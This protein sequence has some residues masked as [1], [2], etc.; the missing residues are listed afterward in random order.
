[1]FFS[2]I[3]KKT[4][5][6]RIELW[7]LF[8]VFYKKIHKQK[9][10]WKTWKTLF[11]HIFK[12]FCMQIC[13]LCYCNK[14]FQNDDFEKKTQKIE[15]YTKST[16]PPRHEKNSVFLAQRLKKQGGRIKQKSLFFYTFSSFFI[17]KK[18][19]KKTGYRL[20]NHIFFNLVVTVFCEG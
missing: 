14:I 2:I 18:S 11:L 17:L 12:R 16:K 1:M 19:T 13:V 3:L 6:D 7:L 20:W 5:I 4:A 15:N 10:Q 9:P 8:F